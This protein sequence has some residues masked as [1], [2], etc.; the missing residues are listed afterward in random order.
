MAISQAWLTA[1]LVTAK[2]IPK[3][4]ELLNQKKKKEKMT[5]E[6]MLTQIKTLNAMFGGVVNK[7]G[8]E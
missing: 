4:E 8:T 3:L 6:Q 2:N 1:K 7:D 5:D